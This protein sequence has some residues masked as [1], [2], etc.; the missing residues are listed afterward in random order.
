[1]QSYPVYLAA[2]WFNESQY[3]IH[4]NVTKLIRQHTTGILSPKEIFDC[5][6]D[7]DQ[8]TREQT[9]RGNLMAIQEAKFVIAI[10]NGK[11]MGTIWEMGYAY[12]RGIPVVG[13]ALNLQGSFNL[14]LAQGCVNVATTYDQLEEI[15][16]W[17]D[18]NG[19][20]IP[21]DFEGAIE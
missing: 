14:M 21:H 10:T 7:A 3:V 13:F 20:L 18:E 6:P 11:D 4:T 8:R 12:A 9:F 16:K 2:P 19:E 1:M 17:Y 5:P 15:L